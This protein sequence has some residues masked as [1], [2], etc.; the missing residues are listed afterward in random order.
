MHAPQPA[1]LPLTPEQQAIV[2]STGNIK[3]NAVA[4][5][6]KTTTVVE[7]AR[8]RPPAAR[9]LYLAFNSAVRREAERKFRAQGLEQVQV[10]T[11]HSLARRY[12]VANSLYTVRKGG[13]FKPY[14]LVDVLT[15]HW[16]LVS[17]CWLRT[18]SSLWTTSATV[19]SSG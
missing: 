2:A 12:V 4:G 19:T 17:T 6:G 8:T 13:A 10:E 5:S 18:S 11:A 16:P 14:E 9:I 1:A 3:I 7:Y 15:V